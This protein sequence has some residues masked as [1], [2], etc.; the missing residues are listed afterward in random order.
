MINTA[1]TR[2][3]EKGSHVLTKKGPSNPTFSRLDPCQRCPGA[4]TYEC[5]LSDTQRR[6]HIESGQTRPVVQGGILI[7]AEEWM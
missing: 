5:G 6:A 4:A 3:N 2:G 7:G 1:Y